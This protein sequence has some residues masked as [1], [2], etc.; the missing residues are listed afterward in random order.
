MIKKSPIY[1]VKRLLKDSFH[2]LS[3]NMMKISYQLPV[4][5]LTDIINVNLQCKPQLMDDICLPPHCGPLTHNDIEPL[6][7]IIRH[8]NPKIV[9]EFGTAY[10][11][12]VANICNNSNADV[13]TVNALPEQMSGDFIT[14]AISK[15][16][17]GYV[18]RKYG[19]EKRVNQIYENTL[20]L[21]II[22]YLS[23]NIVDIAIIDACHDTDYV[24]NDFTKI[25]PFINKNGLILL[26]DTHPSMKDH[27]IGSYVA[28]M[29]LRKMGF[30][31]RHINNTWW[32]FWKNNGK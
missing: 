3:S 25:V 14:Y 9:F 8:L 18:Y 10:G 31:I 17:I 19:F 6:I 21:N 13:I 32:G 24:I 11:N 27:L 30:D 7:K 28:C 12:T 2:L 15:D 23:N 29:K 16:K 4:V 1:T 20:N 22:K 5:D 26:H